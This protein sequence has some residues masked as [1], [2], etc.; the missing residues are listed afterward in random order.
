MKILVL[1]STIPADSEDRV[2]R[3]VLDQAR[4]ICEID[5]SVSIDLLAPHTPSSHRHAWPRPETVDG[6]VMHYRFRYSPRRC[7]HLTAQGILPKISQNKLYSLLLPLL[8]LGQFWATLRHVRT[9]RPDVIYAHWF[10]PQALAAFAVSVLTSTPFGFTTHASDVIVW[11]R[12]GLIGRYLVT[13]VVRRARFVTAV[14]SQT[15][16]KLFYMLRGT[17]LEETRG[18][19][20]LLPMGVDSQGTDTKNGDPKHVVV[21][22]RLVEKKGIRYLIEA[23]PEVLKSVPD[24]SLTIAGDGPLREKLEQQARES[25]ARIEFPGYILG[26]AK[27]ELLQSAGVIALPSVVAADGDADGLPVALL[28]GLSRGCIAVASDASGAQDILTDGRNGFVV[29]AA[30]VAALVEALVRSMTMSAHDRRQMTIA[31]RRTA[32]SFTWPRI[33]RAH[34]GL[35]RD[36]LHGTLEDPAS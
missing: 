12:L 2:P 31:A 26:K 5:T 21:V 7:E 24:A 15:A 22:A 14:S 4:A 11:E 36:C 32:E 23:W 3:F 20:A 9:V 17:T 1:A 30:S 13:V 18:R 35:L 19:I 28:E 33:A 10:T 27:D 6:R 25:R 34:L 16:N 29:P 8:V